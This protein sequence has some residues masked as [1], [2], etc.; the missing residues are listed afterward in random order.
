MIFFVK[1]M[2][3]QLTIGGVSSRNARMQIFYFS[4][5]ELSNNENTIFPPNSLQICYNC[6]VILLLSKFIIVVLMH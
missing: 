3:V 2:A 6:L 4:T 1:Y 5:I